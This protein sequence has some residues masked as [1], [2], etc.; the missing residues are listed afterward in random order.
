MK[1]SRQFFWAAAG[2]LGLLQVVTGFSRAV[3]A[4]P[5]FKF[6]SGKGITIAEPYG[7]PHEQQNKSVLTAGKYLLLPGGNFL[8]SDGVTNRLFSETNTLQ[9][10]VR[11]QQCIYNSTNR[12][13]NSSG[14]IQMQ[15][16]DGKFTIE[17]EGFY[18]LQTNSSLII[19]NNVHTTI[20]AEL[21]HSSPTN[22]NNS[23][24]QTDTAPLFVNSRQFSYDATSGNGVWRDNVRMTGT[25]LT[26]TSSLLIAAVPMKERLLRSLHAE[27]N[28]VVDYSGLSATGGRLD[29]APESGLVR[30]TDHPTWHADQREGRGDELVIDRTNRIFQVNQHAW[31]KLPGEAL[32]EAGFLSFS[33]SP[34]RKSQSSDKGSVEI[35]CA[36]YEFRTNWA[37]F[38]NHVYLEERVA[39]TVRGRL[40]CKDDMIVTFSGTNELQTLTANKDV[41]IEE[42]DK[43]FTGGHAFYTHTNTTLEM[44]E[45]PRW[46]DGVHKGQRA[47]REG[48][49]ELLRLNTQKYE[50]LV[51]SN[52]Y[53]R[54]PANELAGQLS[55]SPL[56]GT[57]NRPAGSG[58]NQFAE[59]Y[60]QEYL[61]RQDTSFF[62]G[63]IYATHPELNLT[64]ETMTIQTPLARTTNLL[65]R[66]NVVFDVLTQKGKLHGTGDDAVYSF[67]LLN[68]ITNGNLAINELRL[69]GT[70][71]AVSNTFNG[72]VSKNDL[73]IWDRA[74]DKLSLP[75]TNYILKGFGKATDTNIFQLPNKKLS[76]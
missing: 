36:S 59:V 30:L 51:S 76:K 4:P 27:T 20:Q 42:G 33:N 41:V 16:A 5:S 47:L 8:F 32:G 43:R 40:T 64:C 49:G 7:P 37:V 28:V 44:T 68:T 56:T 62:R 72:M 6:V 1:I 46:E 66:G 61:L 34:A 58:T 22:T 31:L 38:R 29:Y 53:L 48:K 14:P 18:L 75:G 24:S 52:A 25:N 12:S 60:C 17:G 65:A 39:D 26:L 71:A 21:L 10:V 70:P 63:G 19:S 73:I 23:P 9:L 74:R 3:A 50:L 54:L 2:T 13:V 67:G 55:P 15:T 11:A 35:E 57:T 45:N 69:T